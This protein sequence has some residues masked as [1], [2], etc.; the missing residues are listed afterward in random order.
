MNDQLKHFYE[1]QS[2]PWMT[3]FY[4]LVAA[5]LPVCSGKK[6]LDFGAGFGWTANA[7]ALN[8]EVLALEPNLDMVA[9]HCETHPYEMRCGGP[10]ELKKLPAE[11]F[12]LILCHNVLEYVCDQAERQ[13]ILAEF[14]RLVSTDGKISVIKHHFP[15]A[16]MQR[17]VFENHLDEAQMLL[18]GTA[19]HRSSFGVI[20]YYDLAVLTENIPLKVDK[21]YGIGAFNRL[22]PNAFKNTGDWLEKMFR[23]EMT[24]AEK[25]EFRDIAFFNHLLLQKAKS[26]E[27]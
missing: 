17:I 1:Q 18:D 19:N 9:N 2:T 21:K 5:Q 20:H 10:S 26:D 11:S 22:Q 15:G 8:N 16:I 7:L 3:L 23:L 24:C 4:R 12:D 6:I 14:A 13:E 27:A 25:S